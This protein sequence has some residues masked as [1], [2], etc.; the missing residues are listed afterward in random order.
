MGYAA[1]IARIVYGMVWQEDL[2]SI[3]DDLGWGV[4][5]WRQGCCIEGHRGILNYSPT[6][7]AVRVK[8]GCVCLTGSDMRILSFDA[9]EIRI[10]GRVECVSRKGYE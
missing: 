1:S 7:I 4:H 8:N 3:W 2:R 10:L 9:D 6:E 5:V